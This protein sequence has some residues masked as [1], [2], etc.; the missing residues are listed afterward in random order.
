M[1]RSSNPQGTLDKARVNVSGS[2]GRSG[3]AGGR[4]TRP[5]GRR[6]STADNCLIRPDGAALT[7]ELAWTRRHADAGRSPCHDLDCR[8][9]PSRLLAFDGSERRTGT[10]SVARRQMRDSSA[11]VSPRHQSPAA[12]ALGALVTATGGAADEW[13]AANAM[14][15]VPRCGEET[16]SSGPWRS[17]RGRDWRGLSP[18]GPQC[19]RPDADAASRGWAVPLAGGP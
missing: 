15:R 16:R 19:T 6:P 9:Q 5:D 17:A 14:A 7:I 4:C 12:P 8:G 13:I 1:P 3:H 18:L 11:W 2:H 10:V